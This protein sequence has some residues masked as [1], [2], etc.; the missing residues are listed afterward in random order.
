MGSYWYTPRMDAAKLAEAY[1]RLVAL[2]ENLP[3]GVQVP[4]K[5]AREFE[6]IRQTLAEITGHKLDAFAV[7]ES[8]CKPRVVA[9]GRYSGVKYSKG[10]YCDRAF[11]MMK[12]HG[13]LTLF[14]LQEA[15]EKKQIGFH[16]PR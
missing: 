7:P 15:V 10:L 9:T 8:E 6:T 2:R 13:L 14:S 12:I 16:P 3:E 11:L 1:A 4:E 5:Y